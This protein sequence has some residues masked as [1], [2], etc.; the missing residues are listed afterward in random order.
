VS[1]GAK[2]REIERRLLLA[3]YPRASGRSDVPLVFSDDDDHD[4]LVLEDCPS[5]HG[6]GTRCDERGG[7]ASLDA[8]DAC[9][10]AGTTFEL[11]RY[12][13]SSAPAVEVAADDE[14]WATCPGCSYRFSTRSPAAWTGR[15][16]VRCGQRIVL[17]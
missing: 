14:G 7:V 16:H 2:K 9:D 12:F 8:C 4:P 15:R 6:R 3:K 1:G 11:V 5:C 13:A 10:G 17:T